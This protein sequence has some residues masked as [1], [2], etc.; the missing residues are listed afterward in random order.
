MAAAAW[1][2][3]RRFHRSAAEGED[4]APTTALLDMELD[5]VDRE[6][7]LDDVRVVTSFVRWQ[8][9]RFGGRQYAVHREVSPAADLPRRL[10]VAGSRE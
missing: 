6:A 9:R 3:G 8:V 5:A 10:A 4:L 2:R 7:M 1:Q